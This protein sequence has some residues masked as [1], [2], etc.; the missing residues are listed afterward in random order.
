M[1]NKDKKKGKE[2]E[3]PKTRIIKV[4]V[5]RIEVWHPPSVSDSPTDVAPPPTV[6]EGDGYRSRVDEGGVLTVEGQLPNGGRIPH[7][8]YAPFQWTRAIATH[9]DE[10]REVPKDNYDYEDD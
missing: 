6:W 3:A 10:E 1:A 5:T 9:R 2:Q 4:R 7:A 8:H